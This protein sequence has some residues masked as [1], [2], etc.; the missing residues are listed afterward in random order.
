MIRRTMRCYGIR[1]IA[2]QLLLLCLATAFANKG[3]AQFPNANQASL[4][5]AMMKLF[6]ATTAFSSKAQVRMLDKAQKETMSMP[7]NFA[8]LDHK[9]RLEVDLT[10]LKS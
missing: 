3:H 9:I 1:A 2:Q 4:N 7:M 6:G 5:G 10:Q 8:L